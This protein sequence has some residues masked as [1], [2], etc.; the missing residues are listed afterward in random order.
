ML[1]CY[2]YKDMCDYDVFEWGWEWEVDFCS[3]KL[4]MT[5]ELTQIQAI[6]K[7]MDCS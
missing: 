2:Q 3:R 6:V 4:I 1:C 5:V 7:F